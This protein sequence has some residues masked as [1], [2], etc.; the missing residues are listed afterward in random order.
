MNEYSLITT[1]TN[2]INSA[3]K[4]A[5]L[6]IENRLAACVQLIPIES[7]YSWQNKINEEKEVTL[8]IKSKT[9]LF[10]KI[11]TVIMENHDYEVPQIIQIPITN[12]L[13]Q[14]LN[15]IEDNVIQA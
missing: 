13:P 6:L 12:G 4:I 5:K 9:D 7:I 1:T 10:E 3:K 11:K 14:Y 15:W 2:D 8:L